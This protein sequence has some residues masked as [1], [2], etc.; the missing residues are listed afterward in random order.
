MCLVLTV[1]RIVHPSRFLYQLPWEQTLGL[2]VAA[3]GYTCGRSWQFWVSPIREVQ[4][5]VTSWPEPPALNSALG[6]GSH[7][8]RHGAIG[9]QMGKGEQR[10]NRQKWPTKRLKTYLQGKGWLGTLGWSNLYLLQWKQSPS[11][12]NAREVP[13]NTYY[14]KISHTYG[15]SK[16]TEMITH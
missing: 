8:S 9:K 2:P 10:E 5:W 7:I 1:L 11:P 13:P 15:S 3:P 14:F 6:Q 12:W 16:M 4:L